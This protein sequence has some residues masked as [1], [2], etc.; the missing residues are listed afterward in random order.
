MKSKASIAAIITTVVGLAL[1][2]TAVQAEDPLKAPTE[3]ITIDGKKPVQFDHA[4]HQELGVD[5]AECHHDGEHNPRTAENIAAL[6]DSEVL[7]CATCH[8]EE[9]A[10]PELQNRKTIFHANCRECH[11]EG[12]NGKKGP[13]K[14]SDCHVKKARKAIEGC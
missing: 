8:N 13:T 5:C 3:P 7:Q 14:C 2:I 10:N 4:V 6:S 1:G 9:F 11:Q 12:V